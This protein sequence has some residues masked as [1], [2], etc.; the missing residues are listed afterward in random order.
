M[1]PAE[2]AIDPRCDLG[3]DLVAPGVVGLA[4]VSGGPTGGLEP[5]YRSLE[6]F[7]RRFELGH[8]VRSGGAANGAV[9]RTISNFRR[10]RIGSGRGSFGKR[11]GHN[12][13]P[14]SPT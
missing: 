7:N 3:G 13:Q 9:Q 12:V 2:R 11:P 6:P 5:G 1:D 8:R 4:A 14:T 10:V